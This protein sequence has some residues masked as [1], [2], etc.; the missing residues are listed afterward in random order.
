MII[1]LIYCAPEKL[2]E[3]VAINDLTETVLS[4]ES[5]NDRQ[6]DVLD[7]VYR[8][9]LI[10]LVCTAKRGEEAAAEL[11]AFAEHLDR[12]THPARLIKL[13]SLSKP[14][15]ARWTAY[16]D[17]LGSRLAS[18]ES[19]VPD[20]VM[21]L[22]NVRE[23]LEYIL[24]RG[25]AKRK[26][27]RDKFQLRPANLTRILNTMESSDLIVSRTVGREKLYSPGANSTILKTRTEEDESAVKRGAAYLRLQHAA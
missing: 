5:W 11:R 1:D 25:T 6:A 13:E 8:Q 12:A 27:I 26:D 17:I 3:T 21:S 23:I 22:K 2:A 19:D 7:Y 14:Y 16:L 10:R 15:G 24:D 4:M 20:R 9:I 18:L